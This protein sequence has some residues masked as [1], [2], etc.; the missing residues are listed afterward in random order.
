MANCKAGLNLTHFWLN[1]K[2]EKDVYESLMSL[3]QVDNDITENEDYFRDDTINLGYENEAERLVKECL[4]KHKVISI[5]TFKLAA[6]EVAENIS[7][8]E[9]YGECKLSFVATTQDCLI[10]AFATGGSYSN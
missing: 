3:L 2:S 4:K 7:E 8:Q 9:Y 6:E 10:V 1:V 5:A